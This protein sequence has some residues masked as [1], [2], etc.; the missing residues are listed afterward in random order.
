MQSNNT[1]QITFLRHGESI[2][3]ANSLLQG[4]S[5]W[6]L[7]PKG[8]DQANEL[9]TNWLVNNKSF[10]LIISSPL[11]RAS[12][13]ARIISQQ[14]QLPLIFDPVWS[15]RA[16]GVYEGKSYE[17]IIDMNPEFD[18]SQ[19]I[20]QT[21]GS[22]SLF[23]V[24]LRAG[25]GLLSLLRYPPGAYLV[26]SHGATLNMLMFNILGISP[27]GNPKSPRFVFG[28]TG[29]IDLIYL[30]DELQ[31]RILNFVNHSRQGEEIQGL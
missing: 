31:W 1:Y 29:Y 14:L 23:D 2:A 9:A 15:E 26:V 19:P 18:F 6:N 12:E 27:L 3:N 13:T 7:S 17:E 28:N 22:E 25:I 20:E 21:G 30:T 11:K 24:Y 5:D 8:I 4:Q 16:F 10:D